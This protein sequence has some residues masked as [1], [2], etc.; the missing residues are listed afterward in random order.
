MQL[1]NS[2]LVAAAY[3]NCIFRELHS[4]RKMRGA[5]I[6]NVAYL[7]VI[8]YVRSFSDALY[9]FFVQGGAPR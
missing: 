7:M 4:G 5:D 6:E 2:V 3:I 9:C 8:K 1:V